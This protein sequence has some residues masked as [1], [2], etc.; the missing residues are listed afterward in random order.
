MKRKIAIIALA[1]ALVLSMSVMLFACDSA[2]Q[3]SGKEPSGSNPSQGFVNPGDN[4]GGGGEGVLPDDTDSVQDDIE[5]KDFSDLQSNTSADGTVING[6][7]EAYEIKAAGTYVL[8]GEFKNGIV[9][10]VGDKE[11]TRLVLNVA[12]IVNENGIALS[13]T[14]K[15]SSLIITLQE[16]TQNTITNGTD[17]NAIHVKG[18]LSIN[19][20]GS[21]SVAS[22]AKNAI[23]VS[24][25]FEMIDA[26]VTLSSVNHG[27]SARFV[28]IHN[29]TL[30]VSAASKDGINAE[31]DDETTAFTNEEGYVILKSVNYTCSVEG[32]GIQADTFCKIDGGNIDITTNGK[33]VKYSSANMTE[34]EL[35][36]DDFRYIYSS[37]DYQKVASDYRFSS[38]NAYALTQSCK[39][40]KVGEIKYDEL[41]EDENVIG[42]IVVTDGDYLISI[43]GGCTM[44]INSADDA[45]HTNSGD[46]LVESGN[47][48][49]NTYDDGITSDGLT[50]IRGGKIDIL[51]SYEGIEGAYVKISGGEIYIIASDDGINAATDDRTVTEYIII[52]GGNII[53]NADGDGVDSNGSILVSG[54]SLI[55]YGPTSGMDAALD[56]DSGIIINGGVVWA[57]S[58]LGMVETPS[59]NSE[60]Y[61]VSYAQQNKLEEGSVFTL[62]D[63]DGNALLS[64]DVAKTC[65]SIIF[66]TDK[67]E[68]GATYTIYCNDTLMSTFTVSSTL[69]TIGTAQNAGHGGGGGFGPGGKPGGWWR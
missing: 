68:K 55:V 7:E 9:V 15:K 44:T 51:K 50:E 38:N 67:L 10:K 22:V 43:T 48:T 27:L 52:S 39:G 62:K 24:K 49:I 34:Y 54:G 13:N 53:V 69:T 8:S 4:L 14:N 5:S 16:G 29:A 3:P 32:D 56:A 66:S 11:T 45:I 17:G 57:C 6:S 21:L 41:D 20:K 58:T 30:N 46:V 19:G 28:E 23:K 60:Q 35:E 33:F 65:Q 37:G 59:T 64:V 42:E 31:C 63:S 18:S 25:G 26:N 40:I 2:S 1:L 47:I 12:N 61:V 36:K